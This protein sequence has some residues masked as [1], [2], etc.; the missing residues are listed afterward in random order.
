MVPSPNESFSRLTSGVH[1]S[2]HASCSP[3]SS[4]SSSLTTTSSNTTCPNHSNNVNSSH[5]PL[6]FSKNSSITASTFKEQS[7]HLENHMCLDSYSPPSSSSWNERVLPSR[8]DSLMY[9]H[10]VEFKDTND[11]PC[12]CT[13]CSNCIVVP[14]S[15]TTKTTTSCLKSYFIQNQQEQQAE[16]SN[17]KI[18]KDLDMQPIM[19]RCCHPSTEHVQRNELWSTL[20]SQSYDMLSE[21]SLNHLVE[22]FYSFPLSFELKLVTIEDFQNDSN[23]SATNGFIGFIQ[24]SSFDCSMK[25]F[26][27]HSSHECV[28]STTNQSNVLSQ[29]LKFHKQDDKSLLYSKMNLFNPSS[30]PSST[31]LVT[32][33]DSTLGSSCSSS[34][35]SILNASC[36]ES[37]LNGSQSTTTSSNQN[38]LLNSNSTPQQEQI[39][40]TQQEGVNINSSKGQE[41]LLYDKIMKR[42]RGRPP[43][44][45]YHV[46]FSEHT[47]SMILNNKM[48]AIH[49]EKTKNRRGKNRKSRILKNILDIQERTQNNHASSTKVLNKLKRND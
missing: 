2:C 12:S 40:H 49:I 13:C 10:H 26:N 25:Q 28:G 34:S 16:P 21:F 44:T 24:N 17:Q 14:N 36:S 45:G 3:S 42:K 6:I 30:L 1:S 8:E 7:F 47:Y 32:K 38:L 18:M 23:S 48:E 20:F 5:F 39:L 35:S 41:I 33:E 29:L 31:L 15:P 46:E 22:F 4:S 19:M 43:K 11:I 37:P 9:H 27:D